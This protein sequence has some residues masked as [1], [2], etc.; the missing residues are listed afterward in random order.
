MAQISPTI[1]KAE[2][3]FTVLEMVIVASIIV[4]G[5]IGVLVLVDQIIKFRSLNEKYL[6]GVQLAQEGLELARYVRNDN[7]LRKTDQSFV[8][9]AFDDDI[10]DA[11][12][13]LF[14]IDYRIRA[15]VLSANLTVARDNYIYNGLGG[16]EFDPNDLDNEIKTEAARLYVKNDSGHNFYVVNDGITTETPSDF[17]RLI[18]TVY[19]DNNTPTVDD[20]DYLEVVS[21]VYWQDRGKDYYFGLSTYLYDYDW[22]Y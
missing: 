15:Q 18:K 7:W 5:L 19:H 22:Y 3:G 11:D 4:I 16:N 6:L 12:P 8:N 20:D 13:A 17:H 14:A 1:K 2:D 21:K 10:N 9:S